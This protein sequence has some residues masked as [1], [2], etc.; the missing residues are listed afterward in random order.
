M[1]WIEPQAATDWGKWG[2][3]SRC[4]DGHHV[5]GVQLKITIPG[6]DDTALNAIRFTCSDDAI[7]SS[8]EGAL[9][10]W[11]S[12]IKMPTTEYFKGIQLRTEPDVG[13]GDDTAA[14]GIRLGMTLESSKYIKL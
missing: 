8:S 12:I 5:V 13:S 2:K 6:G 3:E 10:S 4:K 11:G 9:G 7:I 14:N 1:D